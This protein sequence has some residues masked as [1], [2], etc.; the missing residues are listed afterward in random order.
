M[1]FGFTEQEKRL[2]KE[3]HALFLNELPADFSGHVPNTSEKVTSWYMEFQKKAG[4]KGYLT[5]G[6]PREYGGLGLG[7]I[8]QGVV[9]EEMG[10][11]NIRWPNVEGIHIAGPGILLF[12]SEEQKKKFLPPISRGEVRWFEAF[13]EPDAGSD[14]AN[15]QMRAVPDGDDFILN[16]QKTYVTGIEK[17]DFLYT[18]ARTADTTP[19]H[20]GLSLF[21][22]PAD[23]PGI[24]Y[25]PLPVMG[26]WYCNEIFFDDVRIPKESLIGEINRGFYYA[27]GTFEFERANTG[28]PAGM[29]SELREFVQ[30]CK[31]EK[32]NGKPLI[33]DPQVREALAQMA[34]DSEVA[35]LAAWRTT[36]RLGER[37]RLGPLDYDLTGYY[38]VVFAT[39]RAEVMMNILGQYGQLRQGSKWAKLAGQVERR[40]QLARSIHEAGTFEIYLIVL[41]G[42]GLGLPRIPSKLN[43]VIMQALQEKK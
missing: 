14:E 19:K 18:E 9:N 26:G 41:A 7:A 11:W 32:R 31:E 25:R 36:W 29:K 39:R 13:S 5:P 27:M 15:I 30:F 17:P 38:K 43:P 40:W 16:G 37:E 24:S 20:R 4:G 42:R 2:R 34:V 6:W 1:D 33:E 28:S 22:F 12:G 10:Y 8:A 23:L 3:V 35:R 21:V